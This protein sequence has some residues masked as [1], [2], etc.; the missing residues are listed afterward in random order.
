MKFDFYEQYKDYSNTDLQ[1][2]VQQPDAYQPEAVEAA[3]GILKERGVTDKPQVLEL[4]EQTTH[5]LDSFDVT[6]ETKPPNLLILFLITVGMEYLWMVY[7]TVIVFRE[8]MPLYFILLKSIDLAFTPFVFY[9]LWK[10]KSWGWILIF[11]STAIT[12]VTR[13]IQLDL[14]FQYVGLDTVQGLT[15]IAIT[16]LKIAFA[17]YLWRKEIREFFH[18]SK[19][20]K[21]WTAVAAIC[22]L[23]A[24]AF[25]R[26]SALTG[27]I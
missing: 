13:L 20:V 23:V 6:E 3:S 18:V 22:I 17:W 11:I 10:R 27:G 1:K 26:I 16:F 15:Y 25:Y 4:K 24:V 9:L 2:I 8:S 5:L 12:A 14:I 19:E 7:N 21:F